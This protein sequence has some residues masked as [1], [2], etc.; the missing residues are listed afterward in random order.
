MENC[1]SIL[2]GKRNQRIS[3]IFYIVYHTRR[4]EK[5]TNCNSHEI[6][7]ISDFSHRE[8]GHFS[9]L[10]IYTFLLFSLVVLEAHWGKSVSADVGRIFLMLFRLF[11]RLLTPNTAKVGPTATLVNHLTCV[12]TS[13]PSSLSS[14]PP[15]SISPPRPRRLI[16]PHPSFQERSGQDV[17]G[18]D[19]RLIISMTKHGGSLAS[20]GG[21]ERST[22]V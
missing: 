6:R 11:Q 14:P 7:S 12:P 9:E 4:K 2:G 3:L 18:D 5:V 19:S 15:L 8:D 21:L 20:D 13:Y 22:Q 16:P 1:L 10:C 17:V